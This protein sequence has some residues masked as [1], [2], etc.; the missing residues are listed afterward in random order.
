MRRI[1][2][3]TRFLQMSRFLCETH[4]ASLSRQ[5]PQ[6]AA[7]AAEEQLRDFLVVVKQ[8]LLFFPPESHPRKVANYAPSRRGIKSHPHLST[9]NPKAPPPRPQP[10]QRKHF[11]SPCH[12]QYVRGWNLPP[13]KEEEENTK[14]VPP[15]FSRRGVDR[16]RTDA[17]SNLSPPSFSVVRPGVIT[18]CCG[19]EATAVTRDQKT[20]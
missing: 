10:W 2:L 1:R 7:S 4:V 20:P 5:S 15:S 3:G 12:E 18:S 13:Q 6:V 19:E 16:T 11:F 17:G 9:K 8:T 14:E